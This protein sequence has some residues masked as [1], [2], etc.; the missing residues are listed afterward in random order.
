[1][2]VAT[3]IDSFIAPVITQQS[4]YDGIKAAFANA[5]FVSPF[6]EYTSGTERYLVFAIVLDSSKTYGTSYLRIRLLNNLAVVQSIYSTWTVANHTGTNPSQEVGYTTPVN[7]AQ[8]NFVSLNGG[9]EYKLIML[10]QGT[11]V[12]PLGFISPANKPTW[13]DLNAWNYCFFPTSTIFDTW[14]TTNLNPYANTDHN[15]SLNVARMGNANS[16]TNRRDLLPG[17]IVYTTS[18]Q[19][20]S[21]RTSDDLVSVAGNGTTRYDVLQIPGDTKEYLILYPASGG[22][23]VRIK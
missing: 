16:Q 17:I 9:D 23:A 3:R 6:D 8:I 4:L 1:M 14:R 13:W 12:I 20:I 11:I 22:L 15:N 5:G 10:M 21:G 2:V 18:N 7:N 19:G